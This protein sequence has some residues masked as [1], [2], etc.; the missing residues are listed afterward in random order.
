MSLTKR[1]YEDLARD[2]NTVLRHATPDTIQD[3]V[4][5]IWLACNAIS[6]TLLEKHK[7]FSVDLF[8][9]NVFNG[10]EEYRSHLKTPVFTARPESVHAHPAGHLTGSTWPPEGSMH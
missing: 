8:Y 10:F 1:D 4:D 9:A 2:L 3:R 5:T 7:G 6:L